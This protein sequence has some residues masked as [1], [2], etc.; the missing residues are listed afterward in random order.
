MVVK[1]IAVRVPA[2]TANLG[3][4]FDALGM[5]L[6]LYNRIELEE[7]EKEQ[8]LV[9][10][11][12]EGAALLPRDDSN[13]AVRAIASL[14]RRIGYRPAGLRLRLYNEI[15]LASGLGSSAAAIAGGLVAA[16]A[17][18]GNPLSRQEILDQ[19][20]ALE[21]HPDNVA[22]ALLGGVVIVV[23]D[24]TFYSCTRLQ[25]PRNVKITAVVPD[26]RLS[27][28]AAREV[29]PEFVP[30]KD[31]VYNLGRAALLVAALREGNWDLL[32]VAMQDRLH[33]PYRCR[34]VPGLND[35]FAIARKEGAYGAALSG[36]GPTVIAFSPPECEVGEAIR[37][38]F[39]ARGIE[40]RV[41]NLE[42]ELEG[43]HL[44]C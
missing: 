3:P 29:L 6:K 16:N 42:P 30:L 31:A 19:A 43:T 35:I 27:T 38:A 41:L 1:R 14:F 13:L 2:T 26:F 28:K 8:L 25:V 36:A 18:A 10:V 34:L 33:Q 11:E 20:V 12:G 5:S 39:L 37:G 32:G 24:G 7:I 23:Q 17:L 44:I 21:G 22:A 40:A 4:G 15:P 9:E